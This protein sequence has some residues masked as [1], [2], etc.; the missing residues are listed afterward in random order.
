MKSKEKS[1]SIKFLKDR[2]KT[3]RDIFE[4]KYTT[5][6]CSESPE[7]ECSQCIFN[8]PSK[9]CTGTKYDHDFNAIKDHK[10][11]RGKSKVTIKDLEQFKIS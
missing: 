11:G 1:F 5:F 8:N 3:I 7:L 9:G 2:I 10:F 6:L 4:E